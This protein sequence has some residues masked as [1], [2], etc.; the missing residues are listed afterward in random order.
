MSRR[1]KTPK[2][3]SS[4]KT[5][6]LGPYEHAALSCI[7][8]SFKEV[9]I[10]PPSQWQEEYRIAPPGSPRPGKWRNYPYQVEPFDAIMDETCS[11]MALMWASQL[12][13]K[14]VIY[15]GIL[16]WQMDQCPATVLV[17]HP[18]DQVAQAWS[19]NRFG[20]GIE[21][22]EKIASLVDSTETRKGTRSG[23]GQNTVTH[24]KYSGGWT[25]AVGS[26]SGANL[27]GHTTKYIIFDEIDEYVA[28]VDKQG[29]PIILA[30][31]RTA[32]FPDAFSIKTSTPTMKH[33]SRIEKEMEGTDYRRWTCKCPNCQQD[34]VI[35]FGD[36]KWDKVKDEHGKTVRHLTENAWLECPKCNHRM[37]DQ[38]RMQMV[39]LGGWIP[40][41][42]E[43]KAKRGYWANAFIVLGPT[44]RGFTGWLHYFADRYLDALKLPEGP[45]TFQ[46]LVCAETYES[47]QM[48]PPDWQLLYNRREL[49][50]EFE[51]EIVIPE[52]AMM[53]VASADIQLDRI[54][55]EII[56]Y[57]MQDETWGIEYKIFRGNTTLPDIYNE[58]NQ[59]ILKWW[60]HQSG[61]V[62]QPAVVTLDAGNNPKPVYDYSYRCSPRR[63]FAVRGYRG[64]T[65]NWVTRSGG[66]NQRLFILKVDG[67]KE[68]LYSRLRLT[69]YGPGYQ[70]FP[71]N[72]QA[73]YDATFFQQLC[74][75]SMRV[76][77]TKGAYAPYFDVNHSGQR[78]ESLDVRV[79]GMAAYQIADPDWDAVQRDLAT[80][81]LNDWRPRQPEPPK[82]IEIVTDVPKELQKPPQPFI[83]RHIPRS[84][85][86]KP[87]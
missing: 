61:H 4:Q 43:I 75:E 84:G 22:T 46:N 73:G 18:T 79:Y 53:L 10:L 23:Y 6:E 56:A 39:E 40:M 36:I 20:P 62:L 87:F 9:K 16:Y 21:S 55:G 82:P 48:Q 26:N 74:S 64:Y 72:P 69:N 24:K 63:V 77:Y 54:E 17:V 27:R 57:G 7:F 28:S 66:Q 44:K 51:G 1:S 47:E 34:W 58:F 14:S 2:S 86:S 83:P 32:R 76:A 37:N 41:R 5:N 42:P 19:K 30:E 15:E 33:F 71:A 11:S 78:N 81:A 85:W 45:V 59:W 65:P 52:R 35:M 29:D 13:G 25:L 80:P 12:I 3:E 50:Q 38:E 70:H 68:N 60:K 67:A 31:Q 49:Y 8:D